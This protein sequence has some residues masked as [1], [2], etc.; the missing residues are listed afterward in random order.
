MNDPLSQLREIHLPPAVSWWPP[1]PGWWLLV[2]LIVAVGVVA[3]WYLRRRARRLALYRTA[4]AEMA[5]IRRQYAAQADASRLAV[6]LS[7]LLRRVA[8]TLRPGTEVAGLTGEAW[9]S[10]L[11]AQTGG[12]DFTRGPGRHLTEAAYSP[13]RELEDAQALLSLAQTWLE[14]VT[15]EPP[16]V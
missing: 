14:K 7:R 15:R 11:D 10:W 3:G 9:L 5:G 4:M 2:L 6:D 16:H 13:V 1:A 8:I 12:K